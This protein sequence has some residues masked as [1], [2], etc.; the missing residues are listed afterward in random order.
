M[1]YPESEDNG[2]NMA[3]YRTVTFQAD[4]V[5]EMPRHVQMWLEENFDFLSDCFVS[6]KEDC[7]NHCPSVM[8]RADF[9]SFI[10]CMARLSDIDSPLG[11]FGCAGGRHIVHDFTN[12]Y[13]TQVA[14]KEIKFDEVA[15]REKHELLMSEEEEC[16]C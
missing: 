7:E 12:L 10:A 1:S 3:L 4:H 6:L 2:K 8:D 14:D 11:P 9:P 16:D 13:K 15:A 5:Q